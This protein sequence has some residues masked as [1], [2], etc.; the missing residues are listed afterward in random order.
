MEIN[1]KNL[2]YRYGVKH[3]CGILFLLT[4]P[5]FTQAAN[6]AI[7]IDGLNESQQSLAD[8]IAAICPTLASDDNA[9]NLDGKAQQLRQACSAMVVTSKR[10]QNETGGDPTSQFNMASIT[11][12]EQYRAALSQIAHE[13]STAHGTSFTETSQKQIGNIGA[14]LRTLR[15]GGAKFFSAFNLNLKNHRIPV[16]TLFNAAEDSSPS[17]FSMNT[18]LSFYLNGTLAYGAKESTANENGFDFSTNGLTFGSDLQLGTRGFLGFAMGY[19]N[20]K[21]DFSSST[22]DEGMENRG[23]NFSLYGTYYTQF[24]FVNGVFTLG[25]NSIENKRTVPLI[26]DTDPDPAVTSY[27]VTGTETLTG[28]TTANTLGISVSGGVDSNVGPLSLSHY[29]QIDYFR[30]SIDSYDEKGAESPLLLHVDDESIN[31]LTSVFGVQATLASSTPFGV[32]T[33]TIRLQWHHQFEDDRRKINA[34]YI[35]DPYDT[36]TVFY[37]PT[38]NPDRDYFSLGIGVSTVL[39]MGVQAFAFFEKTLDLEAMS[40]QAIVVGIRKEKF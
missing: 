33:D 39:P 29:A 8:G 1:K 26:T 15:R 35:Y 17:I 6:T 23:Y 40:H 38:D 19:N 24:A 16:N 3:F 7:T 4:Y 14:R 27:D 21:S 30:V 32:I 37:A 5:L 36:K 20:L 12:V 10:L 9:G 18:G 11:S 25:R 22:T 13:E 28:K 34:N 2:G 31:S